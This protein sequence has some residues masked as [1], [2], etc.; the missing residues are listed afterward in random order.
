MKTLFHLL[1]LAAVLGIPNSGTG[2]PQDTADEQFPFQVKGAKPLEVLLDA[3]AGEL[4]VEKGAEAASGVVNVKYFKDEYRAKVSFDEKENRLRIRLNKEDWTDIHHDENDDEGH[5]ARI[6][7]MLPHGVDVLFDARL[8]AGECLMNVGGLRFREFALSTWA[9]KTE[10]RFDEPNAIPMDDLEIN[11][12]VGEARLLKLGNARFK[13]AM[14]N[15][16]IGEMNVDFSGELERDCRAK[17]DLD[18]G[19]ATVRLP[20]AIGIRLHIGGS[21]GFLSHKTIDDSFYKRGRY[22]YTDDYEDNGR[23]LYVLVTPGLGEL[24]IERE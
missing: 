10:V 4:I 21:L 22:Y 20:K 17:V 6:H 12:E 16:G 24:R 14:V 8:K 3:D 19:E 2:Q 23:K 9:G 13:E 18:I 7:M 5:W 1:V 11:A 15:G